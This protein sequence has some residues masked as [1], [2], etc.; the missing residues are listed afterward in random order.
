MAR[1]KRE[2]AAFAMLDRH[3]DSPI[4]ALNAEGVMIDPPASFPRGRHPLLAGHRGS[5][6]IT[7]IHR[8]IVLRGWHRVLHEGTSVIAAYSAADGSP[9]TVFCYD[10]REA[11]GMLVML[12]ADRADDDPAT[13]EAHESL[14]LPPRFATMR[15]DILGHVIGVDAAAV[16][17]FGWTLDEVADVEPLTLVHPDDQDQVVET[18]IDVIATPGR[19]NRARGRYARRDGSWLWAECTYTN[20]LEDPAYG[21]VLTEVADIS[22]EMAAQEALQAREEML[23]ELTEALP[24]GVLHVDGTGR[25]LYAN[26]R[27]FD[28]VGREGASTILEQLGDVVTADA[29]QLERAVRAVLEQGESQDLQIGILRPRTG[30]VRVYAVTMRPLRRDSEAVTGAIACVDDITERSRMH[31]ELEVRATFDTLTASY[32]RPSIMA[33]LAGAMDEARHAASGTAAMYLDLDDFKGVNDRLG[34]AAGDELLIMVA[35]RLRAAMRGHDT[36]GRLGGDEFLIV[37]PGVGGPAEALK[38]AARIAAHVTPAVELGGAVVHPRASVGV[39]WVTNGEVDAEAL[40]ARADLAMYESKRHQDGRPTMWRA[41][42]TH[43]PS[44]RH[45][46]IPV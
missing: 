11:H 9:V 3:P 20:R 46:G 31:D 14:V 24:Q 30:D 41:E 2:A 5:D 42:L 19:T 36:I 25:I 13:V 16:E 29:V 7:A 1:E 38:A 8:G 10:L 39:A 23:F 37:C 28:L 32:N 4:A 35:D 44:T 40:V 34:H 27:M 15:R 12:V 33:A 6:A 45:G 26:R 18:W 17:M 43:A 21:D 22:N